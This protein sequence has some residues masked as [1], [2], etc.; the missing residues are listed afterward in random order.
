[1][2]HTITAPISILIKVLILLHSNVQ[3]QTSVPL[4]R[5]EISSHKTFMDTLGRTTLTLSA[6]NVIDDARDQPLIVTYEYPFMAGFRKPI[7]IFAGVLAVFTTAWAIGNVD[8]S[9]G[10]KKKKQ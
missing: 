10:R 3:Y 6:S 1:M 2:S 4:V 9:I 8:T 5:V 7:T